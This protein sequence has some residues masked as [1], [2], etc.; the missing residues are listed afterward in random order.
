MNSHRRTASIAALRADLMTARALVWM[1][2]VGRD[3]ELT[4]EAHL[5]FADRYLRLADW[6]RK[7][8]HLRRARELQIKADE[9]SRLGGDGPPYAAALGMPHPARWTRTNA[10]ASR[11]WPDDAA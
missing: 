4:A 9:H 2:S 3:V 8:G 11:S 5:Y 10:V 1:V 6:H 7:K